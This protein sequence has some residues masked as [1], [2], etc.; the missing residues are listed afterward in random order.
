MACSTAEALAWDKAFKNM[1]EPS[2]RAG[3]ALCRDASH[4]C[5]VLYRPWQSGCL[6]SIVPDLDQP[7]ENILS[8]AY[9]KLDSLKD[10]IDLLEEK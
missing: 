4:R 8:I 6:A 1:N 7:G 9:A 10:V 2:G 3:N 5:R